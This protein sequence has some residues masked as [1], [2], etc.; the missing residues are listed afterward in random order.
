MA[1]LT[2]SMVYDVHFER[3]TIHRQLRAEEHHAASKLAQVHM[4]LWS[5]YRDDILES[6][7]AKALLSRLDSSYQDFTSKYQG[8]T[9]GFAQEIGI[10]QAKA[11]KFADKILHMVADMQ[12]DNMKHAK[13]L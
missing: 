3:K 13:R 6:N 11:Q 7:E 4:E 10:N 2:V 8:A 5:Q 12:S 1:F 9:E